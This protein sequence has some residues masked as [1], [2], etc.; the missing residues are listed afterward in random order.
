MRRRRPGPIATVLWFAFFVPFIPASFQ[1]PGM[2][3]LGVES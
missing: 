3:W 1:T 2:W